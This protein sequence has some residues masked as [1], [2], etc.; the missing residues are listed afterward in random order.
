MITYLELNGFKTFQNFKIELSPFTVIAGTNGSGKSNLFDGLRLLSRIAETDL[1]TAFNEQRGDASELFTLYSDG[2]STNLMSF[3]VEMLVDRQIKDSWGGEVDLKYTRLRYELD[4]ERR[5]DSRQLERLYVQREKLTT[6]KVEDDKWV[7]KYIS[8]FQE[9]WRPKVKTGKRGI[10]YI[11][12]EIDVNSK[13]IQLHQDGKGG[14]KQSPAGIIEQTILSSVN[15]VEF[16][17]ALAAKQEMRNWHFLQLNPEEL[18]KP[19]PRLA[20]DVISEDGSNLAAAL[21]RIKL[22]DKYALKGISR[23]L[24]NLLPSFVAVEVDEDLTRDQYVIKLKTEDKRVFSSKVLSEGTLRLLALCTLKYDNKY[25]GVLNFEEPENGVHPFR[26][27]FVVKLLKELTTD[28][29]QEDATNAPL[30][31]VITNT[32]SPK[33]IGEIFKSNISAR[34]LFAS[35]INVIIPEKG[36]KL[37]ATKML[38]VVYHR[39]GNQIDLFNGVDLTT[40]EKNITLNEVNSYLQSVDFEQIITK[41]SEFQ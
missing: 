3:V 4:I 8:D 38:P 39:Q 24:T 26:L 7:K 27:E 28:F 37:R 21:F 12:T 41:K 15:S 32:H 40:Q 25:N 19:S 20:K 13:R 1:K 14:L 11:S 30:R 9:H 16:P 34:I 23:E 36:E 33:F 6:I 10:P 29:T 17:H 35:M 31:Q 18:R 2:T 5:K 22:D